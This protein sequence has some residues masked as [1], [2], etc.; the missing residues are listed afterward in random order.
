M[1]R[2]T[3]KATFEE[4]FKGQVKG[5]G[6]QIFQWLRMRTGQPTIKPDTHI[7]RFVEQ[8]INRTVSDEEII[9]G[10]EEV[11]KSMGILAHLLDSRIWTK[12]SGYDNSPPPL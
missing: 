3:E 2:W 5:A 7:R 9:N 1:E 10:L 8:I 6:L 4:D 11:A 12:M